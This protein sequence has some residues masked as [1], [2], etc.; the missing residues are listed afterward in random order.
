MAS[1]TPSITPP[2]VAM[3]ALVFVDTTKGRNVLLGVN[4]L[5]TN[6]MNM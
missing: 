3:N 4:T 2:T 5:T 6:A 1:S